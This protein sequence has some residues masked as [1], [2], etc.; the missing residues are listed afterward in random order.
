MDD[1]G[2]KLREAETRSAGATT[3]LNKIDRCCWCC[4]L[5]VKN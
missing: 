2:A 4:C 3:E 5:R 1:A